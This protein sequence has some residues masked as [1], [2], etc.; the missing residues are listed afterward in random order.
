MKESIQLFRDYIRECI[1]DLR[2]SGTASRN[3]YLAAADTIRE[4]RLQQ[5][6]PGLWEHPPLMLTATID[7]GWGHGLEVIHRFA[8]A[9]GLA[10]NPLGLLLNPERIIEE[11]RSHRPDLLGLTVLQFDS[12]DALKLIRKNIPKRTRI[13]AGGPL[14]RADPDFAPRTG[15][16]AAVRD[17]AGFLEFVLDMEL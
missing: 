14:F 5:E 11:C 9:V 8:E 10:C 6:I 7:D 4:R 17:A 3:A 15:I 13:V 16:D 12:E 2:E 1:H